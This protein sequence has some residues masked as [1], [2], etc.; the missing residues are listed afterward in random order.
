MPELVIADTSCFI[1]LSRT[2]GL[3]LL[4]EL[5]GT[6][7]T[8]SIV[9]DEFGSPLPDWVLISDPVDEVRHRMLSLQL[10]RGEASAIALALE[11]PECS[12]IL[13]ERKGRNLAL[14]LGLVV[15]G[16]LG[17][18]VKAKHSGLLDSVEPWLA[19]FQDAGFRYSPEVEEA[20]LRAA[21]ER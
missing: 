3:W 12:I 7:T 8:T 13:D 14:A 10:D 6:V 16:T 18:I 21:G 19:R 11:T 15:T 1:A 4:K 20:V 2:E 9:R 17:V 5:Y